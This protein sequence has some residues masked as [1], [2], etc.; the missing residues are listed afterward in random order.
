MIEYHHLSKTGYKINRKSLSSPIHRGPSASELDS[1]A[2]PSSLFPEKDFHGMSRPRPTRL[3]QFFTLKAGGIELCF[4]GTP[5]E[6]PLMNVDLV[7]GI[8]FLKLDSYVYSRI[9][10]LYVDISRPSLLVNLNSHSSFAK[11]TSSTYD[12]VERRTDVFV[13]DETDDDT[14][15]ARCPLSLGISSLERGMYC[16][17]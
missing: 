16:S 5:S 15:H 12:V 6:F 13:D 17:M 14:R 7:Y 11:H 10:V 9:D 3:R 4:E 8:R 2:V 1:I